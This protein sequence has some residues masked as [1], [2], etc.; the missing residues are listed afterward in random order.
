VKGGPLAGVKV[1]ELAGIGP[2]PFAAMLLA[3]LGADVLRVERA[4]AVAAEGALGVAVD[5][6]NRGKRSV[7]ADLKHPGGVELVLELVARAD[8]LIEGFRPGVVE[9]LGV[10]PDVC[11]ASNRRLVYGRMTGWGQ[12]GPLATV[13]GHDIGYISLAGVLGMV[14]RA[15]EAPVPPLNLVGDFGGGGMLL[16]FGVAAALVEVGRSGRGQVVDAAMVDGAALLST[17]IWELR[18]SGRWEGP[19]GTN[20]LDTGAH[21]YN[22]YETSDGRYVAVGAMEPQFYAE[23]LDV[24]GL[25]GEELPSQRDRSKWPQLKERFAAVFRT[26]TR[27]EWGALAEGR[28]CCLTAV[29]EMDETP[30]HPHNRARHTFVEVD[31]VV[32]PAPA[33]RFSGTPTTAP[34]PPPS[35]GEG[36]DEALADWG[37]AAEEVARLREAGAIAAAAS[38]AAVSGSRR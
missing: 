8:V 11:L 30:D 32:Q 9:R 12:D 34:A 29:L 15:G 22:V 35:P 28:D 18:G 10:G 17:V 1:V 36:A 20:V 23:L 19:R 13:A 7:G 38:A 31:G 27:D 4:S 21:Y 16:A 5:P 3:D 24:M 37:I 6:L 25:A 14:G 26:R 2:G 33:P